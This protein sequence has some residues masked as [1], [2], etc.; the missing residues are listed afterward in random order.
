M[1][2]P[3]IGRPFLSKPTS[4]A[5]SIAGLSLSVQ[6]PL[7]ELIEP[8]PVPVVAPSNEV[9]VAVDHPRIECLNH[10]YK[11]GWVNS[12]EDCWLRG[13][14]ADRLIRALDGL[15]E[16]FGFAIFDAWR[17]RKLQVELYDHAYAD[18]DLPPGFLA[19]PSSDAELP[20]PH[21]TGGAVDLTLTVGGI[22]I[23]AGT[24]FDDFTPKAAA[25]AIEQEAG[26]DRE[27]RRLLYR[28]MSNVGFVV[29]QGEW[30]HF[31]Y[32]TTRW[33]AITGQ[34]PIYGAASPKV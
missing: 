22:A 14:V 23:A 16:Q 8:E 18:P 1:S 33:A 27:A 12:V 29:L 32:G 6:P 21:E 10:Y 31:E 3:Q 9:L 4:E 7:P 11:G 26:S 13:E 34:T 28:V 2:K 24:D 5:L 17:P 25:R 20:A 15:P 19:V 30:W